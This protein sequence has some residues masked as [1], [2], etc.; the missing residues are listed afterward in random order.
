MPDEG[1]P[2][3]PP[4]GAPDVNR[5][6]LEVPSLPANAELCRLAVAIFAGAL[7]FTLSEIEQLKVAISEAVGNCALHAYPDGPGPV[8]V[9]A[10]IRG[11]ALWVEVRDWG[12]GIDD[13]GRARQPAFTTSTDPDRMGLGFAFMEQFTDALEVDSAPGA[14][15]AVR[16]WK[17]P[18]EPLEE[19]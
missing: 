2:G 1:W 12:R 6:K 13:V 8:L 5:M 11:G 3:E 16:M 15:T 7:P 17:R 10:G 4:D 9:R 18:A 14:G 19:S